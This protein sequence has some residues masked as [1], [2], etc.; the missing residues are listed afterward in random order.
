MVLAALFAMF[1]WARPTKAG[2]ATVVVAARDLPAG[3]SI[4]A[5]DLTT[6][7]WPTN[8][9]P[10]SALPATELTGLVTRVRISRGSPV[11]REF[12]STVNGLPT[13]AVP[14]KRS[15]P[16]VR[17]GDTVHVWAAYD[18]RESVLA[19]RFAIVNTIVAESKEFGS[20]SGA[21]AILE[22]DPADEAALAAAREVVLVRQP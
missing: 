13:I 4:V 3:T 1:L 19:A 10:D 15:A 16:D 11:I 22:I 14:L 7:A 20:S 21:F 12:V 17:V 9:I 8:G 6:S 5:A 2:D 18:G